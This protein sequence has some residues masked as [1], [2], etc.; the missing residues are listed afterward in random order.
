MP[1]I[2]SQKGDVVVRYRYDGGVIEV[3]LIGIPLGIALGIA[4][5]NAA[6][7]LLHRYVLHGRGRRKGSFW[8]FHYFEHHRAARRAEGHDPAYEQS[9]FGWHAQGKEALGLVALVVPV[10]AIVPFA[11]FF[12]A[13]LIW[14][15]F[16]YYRKHRRAHLDPA[17]ARRHLPWHYD[18]H[19]GPD[20]DANW[21]VTYPWFDQIMGTRRPYVG[22][23]RETMDLERRGRALAARAR[24]TGTSEAEESFGVGAPARTLD[25]R[26]ASA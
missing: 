3:S 24:Q 22:T 10:L 1:S 15:G 8:N 4:V 21:C 9:P 17:W 18:H 20:Q 7:W 16:D 19:M 6:E 12:S 11:P 2:A 25:E 14:S 23:P 13:T 5:A 26:E